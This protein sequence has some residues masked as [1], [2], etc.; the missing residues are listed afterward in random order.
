MGFTALDQSLSLFTGAL[1]VDIFMILPPILND[2][3]LYYRT[4]T[5]VIDHETC[6]DNLLYPPKFV[7]R[8]RIIYVILTH[9]SLNILIIS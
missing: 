2:G 1:P 9:C 7:L 8:L 5:G 6:A 3:N 4:L